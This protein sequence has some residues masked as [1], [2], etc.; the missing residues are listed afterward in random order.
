MDGKVNDLFVEV[1]NELYRAEREHEPIN[2]LHEGY[3]VIAEELDEFWDQVKRKAR[4]RDPVSVRTEL[5]QTAAMCVQPDCYRASV[6]LERLAVR[7]T[8]AVASWMSEENRETYRKAIVAVLD[9]SAEGADD[10]PVYRVRVLSPCGHPLSD[11]R[12]VGTPDWQNK[13]ECQTCGHVWSR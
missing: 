6:P 3:A 1:A 4:D 10:K 12:N 9:A 5:I 2:S 13:W 11:A 7:L 8:A